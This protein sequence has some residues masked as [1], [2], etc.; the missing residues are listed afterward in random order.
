MTEAD[1]W[2]ACPHPELVKVRRPDVLPT[3][4]HAGQL[5]RVITP[6]MSNPPIIHR[7]T[8]C[9]QVGEKAVK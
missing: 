4:R 5:R 2:R 8:V 9:G 3:V 1:R 7:C 6:R